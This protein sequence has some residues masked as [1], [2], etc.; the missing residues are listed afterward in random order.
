MP[1]A[2]QRKK[3]VVRKKKGKDILHFQVKRSHF[4]AALVAMAFFLGIAVG[5]LNWGRAQ[6]SLASGTPGQSTTQRDISSE[7]KNLPR[8]EVPIGADDP[9]LGP[10][11]APITIIEFADF[12]CPFCQRHAQQVFPRLMEEFGDQVRFVYK[13]FPLSNSHPNAFPA[14][15]SAQCAQEQ[16]AFWPYHDLLFS[17]RLELGRESYE[18]YAR[19]LGLKMAD[20]VAC[21]DEESYAEN[22]QAD[23]DLGV[24]LGVA[25]TPTFF[26][27][28]IAVVG[29]QP[30]DLFAQIIQ[31]ELG[32]E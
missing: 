15:L 18:I 22:V 31:Y 23:Y 16:D 32:A 6:E 2:P 7:L 26:I 24:Q 25:S 27:N 10:E 8:Y 3:R 1:A 21:L 20:F 29:A 13:D 28:G 9:I 5:Y 4:Y 19:Q 12:E 17:G 14:A 30:Y 11:E